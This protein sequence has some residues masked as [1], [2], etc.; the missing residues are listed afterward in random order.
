MKRLR[1]FK[2]SVIPAKAGIQDLHGIACGDDLTALMP[3]AARRRVTFLSRQES[4][5]R[6]ALPVA[7]RP[8]AGT[9][10]SSLK[11]GAAQLARIKKPIRAQTVL[12]HCSGLSCGARRAPTGE[13]Q[14]QQH[15]EQFAALIAPYAC[16]LSLGSKGQSS[17]KETR[18]CAARLSVPHQEP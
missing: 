6:N 14:E 16:S 7:R 17:Q 11:P 9:L 1:Q 4:N 5:Q 3:L 10:R 13:L 18:K 2:P 12:A 8:A 15:L